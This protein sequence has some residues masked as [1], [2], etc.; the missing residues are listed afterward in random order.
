MVNSCRSSIFAIFLWGRTYF[1]P[2]EQA[3][4]V[5][6]FFDGFNEVILKFV[7]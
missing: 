1:N 2:E 6:K 5:K 7:D 3:A 4:P